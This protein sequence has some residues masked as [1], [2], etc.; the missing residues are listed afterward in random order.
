MEGRENSRGD[1]LGR[2]GGLSDVD[3]AVSS[4]LGD[5]SGHLL[6]H[7]LAGFLAGETEERK[8]EGEGESGARG[9]KEG[10]DQLLL[11]SSPYKRDLPTATRPVYS[12]RTMI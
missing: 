8:R 1:D 9:G 10:N 2:H 11:N 5:G 12:S 7:E 4:E 6:V 3:E